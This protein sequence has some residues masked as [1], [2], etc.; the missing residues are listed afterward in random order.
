MRGVEPWLQDFWD[1]R[2]AA[3]F[4]G[5]DRPESL[6]PGPGRWVLACRR[7]P[8]DG[9]PLTMDDGLDPGLAGRWTGIVPSN[10]VIEQGVIYTTTPD[11]QVLTESEILRWDTR[12]RPMRCETIVIRSA[13]YPQ[14]VGSRALNIFELRGDTVTFAYHDFT[15]PKADR[16]PRDFTGRPGDRLLTT[17]WS[18]M[19]GP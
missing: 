4:M 7:D 19:E 1:W 12:A 15:S 3:N 18:R 6:D 11:G 9:P 5:G 14:L 2:A 8:A 17:T 13:E 16:W 10:M